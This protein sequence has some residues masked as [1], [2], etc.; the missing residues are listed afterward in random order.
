MFARFIAAWF[1]SA[2]VLNTTV[3]ARCTGGGF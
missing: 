1:F 3:E 2:T